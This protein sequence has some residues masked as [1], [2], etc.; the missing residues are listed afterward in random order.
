[1]SSRVRVVVIFEA[2]EDSFPFSNGLLCDV[3][4]FTM[5]IEAALDMEAAEVFRG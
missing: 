4:N 2:I 5:A 3:M 1:M